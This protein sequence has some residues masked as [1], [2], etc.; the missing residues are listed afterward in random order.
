MVEY[1][2]QKNT[3][4]YQELVISNATQTDLHETTSMSKNSNS[5]LD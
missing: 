5:N 3:Y 1:T 4:T 2:D